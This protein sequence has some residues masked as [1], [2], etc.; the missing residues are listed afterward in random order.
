MLPAASQMAREA[1]DRAHHTD[2][3]T[4]R[5]TATAPLRRRTAALLRALACRVDVP[6]TARSS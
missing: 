2:P 5:H 6:R 3:T 4:P 1:I